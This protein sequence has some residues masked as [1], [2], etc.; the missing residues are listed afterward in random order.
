MQTSGKSHPRY[1]AKDIAHTRLHKH[2][3]TS[4]TDSRLQIS[5]HRQTHTLTPAHMHTY[6]TLVE[7]RAGVKTC[8]N[9]ISRHI[10][11]LVSK[12]IGWWKSGDADAV[13]LTCVSSMANMEEKCVRGGMAVGYEQDGVREDEAY[14]A[15]ETLWADDETFATVMAFANYRRWWLEGGMSQRLVSLAPACL[16]EGDS[17]R[18]GGGG[19][20]G[21]REMDSECHAMHVHRAILLHNASVY[22]PGLVVVRQDE[23]RS[24]LAGEDYIGHRRR[25]GQ[26]GE[27]YTLYNLRGPCDDRNLFAVVPSGPGPVAEGNLGLDAAGENGGSGLVGA[28]VL[29]QIWGDSFYHW[30]IECLPRLASLPLTLVHFLRFLCSV[31]PVHVLNVH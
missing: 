20:E 17:V 19:G 31:C 29:Q 30:V 10:S 9:G 3:R 11:S 21:A 2:L 14:V 6:Q 13:H 22:Y 12:G 25:G 18:V 4:R 1:V 5:L 28:I 7:F 24:G 16:A 27:K 26:T 8:S 23:E 15:E